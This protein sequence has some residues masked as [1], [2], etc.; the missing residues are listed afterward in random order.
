MG[1]FA[2]TD[3]KLLLTHENNRESIPRNDPTDPRTDGSTVHRNGSSNPTTKGDRDSNRR[4]SSK[5]K[6]SKDRTNS[7]SPSE[8]KSQSF[9]SGSDGKSMRLPPAPSTKSKPI[10]RS[11]LT[12]SLLE[13]HDA[14]VEIDPEDEDQKKQF[15]HERKRK[16]RCNLSF[17]FKAV[18]KHKP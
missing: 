8:W 4:M 2:N 9:T 13:Q 16:V 17:N 5:H 1:S 14:Y 3:H 10:G 6:G 12:K 18:W 7:R 15:V 11:G